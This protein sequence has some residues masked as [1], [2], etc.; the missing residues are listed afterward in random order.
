MHDT[1]KNFHLYHEEIM[2]LKDYEVSDQFSRFRRMQDYKM[3]ITF[4]SL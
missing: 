2:H 1:D 3:K 4:T